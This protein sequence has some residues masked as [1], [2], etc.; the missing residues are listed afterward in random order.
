MKQF[1]G[2]YF[3]VEVKPQFVASVMEA[4]GAIDA[5][6]VLFSWT[7][8]KVPTGGNRLIGITAIVRSAN[9]TLHSPLLDLYFASQTQGHGGVAA[10]SA[11]Q[12]IGSLETVMKPSANPFYNDLIGSAQI[13][14]DDYTHG[15]HTSVATTAIGTGGQ[16]PIIMGNAYNADCDDSEGFQT[17]YMAATTP[18]TP[19]FHSDVAVNEAGFGAGTQTV[20]TVSGTDALEV[21]APGDIIH[22]QDDA[23]LGTISTVDSATQITLTAANTEAIVGSDGTA[24]RLY[25]IHPMKFILSFEK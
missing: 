13:L 24:D 25:N 4:A 23:V 12:A 9:G 15:G 8:F 20:I 18:S 5:N 16:S 3:S 1:K 21:F 22:A 14:A 17:V 10:C 7:P 19:N 11:P 2:K 6:D